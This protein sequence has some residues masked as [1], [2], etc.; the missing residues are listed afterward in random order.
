MRGKSLV[1]VAALTVVAGGL[2]GVLHAQQPDLIS[3]ANSL[4]ERVHH[5]HSTDAAAFGDPEPDYCSTMRSAS[6]TLDALEASYASAAAAGNAAGMITYALV[7]RRLSDEL[8]EEDALDY[9]EG[10]KD[11]CSPSASDPPGPGLTYSSFNN[12]IRYQGTIEAEYGTL[13]ADNGIRTTLPTFAD[14]GISDSNFALG[15]DLRARVPIT[16]NVGVVFGGTYTNYFNQTARGAFDLDPFSPGRDTDVTLKRDWSG[17]LYGGLTVATPTISAYQKG[18]AGQPGSGTFDTTLWAGVHYDQFN[19]S[20]RTNELGL[21]RQTDFN[22]T[23]SG[24]AI[25]LDVD[26]PLWM[27]GFNSFWSQRTKPVLRLGVK[28][29]RFGDFDVTHQA[30]FATY[31]DLIQPRNQFSAKAGIGLQFQ[32]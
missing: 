5:F 8:G 23:S 7:A 11:W 31:R 22:E 17:T 25:G 9:W 10:P 18:I 4:S 24:L 28:Y 13:R 16:P 27:S 2:P 26:Y 1:A 6:R 20:I 15:F 32:P 29:E 12:A 3:Q 21:I 14:G 30:N 19:G